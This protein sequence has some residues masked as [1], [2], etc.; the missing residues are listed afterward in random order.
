MVVRMTAGRGKD[1]LLSGRQRPEPTGRPMPKISM[2]M[3]KS[4]FEVSYDLRYEDYDLYVVVSNDLLY[5]RITITM[6]K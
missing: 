4:D 3:R 2:V 5:T 6:H 1:H